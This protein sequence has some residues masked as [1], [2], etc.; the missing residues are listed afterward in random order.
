MSNETEAPPSDMKT[1]AL[2]RIISAIET[3]TT[4][5]ELLLLTLNEAASLLNVAHGAVVMLNDDGITT[6]LLST[7]PPRINLPPPVPLTE[8]P[9]LFEAIQNRHSV[10]VSDVNTMSSTSVYVSMLKEAQARSLLIVPLVAQDQVKGL[11]SL[12]T[13]GSPR[14]FTEQDISLSRML[15][16]QLAAAITAFS[17]TDAAQRRSAELATLNNISSAVTSSLDTQEI[18]HLVVE[19]LNEY[20]RVEAGSLLMRDE[21]S[22]DL[23]FVMTLEAGEEKLAG[24]IIPRGEGVVG[25]VAESQHYAIVPDPSNDPRFYRKISEKTG[26]PTRSILCVPMI[27]K[28]RT[29]GVIELLNKREGD[30]TPEDANR[31][32]R[33]AATIGVALE[34][35]RLFQE[36]ATGRDR[37]EAILNSNQDGILMSDTHGIVVTANPKA[38]HLLQQTQEQLLGQQ[39]ENLLDT[40]HSNAIDVSIP[41]VIHEQ[42][43]SSDTFELELNSPHHCFIRQISLPVHDTNNAVIGQLTLLQDISGE[44]ELAQLRDDYTGMLVHD[45][46]APLTAIM[47]GIMMV[48][49]GLGGPISPQQDEL[50][51]IAYNSSQTMMEMVNTLLDISKMEQGRMV[52]DIE[53]FPPY[54]IVNETM[55]RLNALAENHSITFQQE[56]PPEMPD[57]RADREKMTRV[58]QNLIDNAV[59]FSPRGGIVTLGATYIQTNNSAVPNNQPHNND[60]EATDNTTILPFT[61]PDIADGEWLIFWV[62]DQGPGIPPQYRE[63]IFEKFGQIRNR[64]VRGTGLGLTFCKLVT[65]SHGGKIWVESKEG[66]GSIFAL[67]IPLHHETAVSEGG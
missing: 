25:S 4:L 10:Q 14:T 60:C 8:T 55:G 5:D 31:L 20:F 48:R 13:V 39:L 19:K 3:A 7:Y 59:K 47:N 43:S 23:E 42:A 11:L 6:R 65:E 46:R 57:L 45:L 56:I 62:K 63:R 18:Y 50:L 1:S 9:Y 37:L 33:M 54:T 61:L 29:I 21:Q 49:R 53:L 2:M 22:G 16:G 40:L 26:Y 12:S 44:R 52:L 38:A 66:E 51:G 15:A 32:M 17:I 34:N 64:K 41:S 30:F 24:V 35:A 67:T 36:V 58:L 27:V 28:G